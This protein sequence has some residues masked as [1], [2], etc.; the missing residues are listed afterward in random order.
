M[1]ARINIITLAVDDL[2]KA[3]RFYRDGLGLP[4]KGIAEGFSDHVLFE[5]ENDLSLVLFLRSET[6]KLANQPVSQRSA[7]ESI[8]SY[9][10]SSKEEVNDILRQQADHYQERLRINHGDILL[11]SRIPMDISGKYC[12]GLLSQGHRSQAGLFN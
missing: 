4:T 8:L 6:A 9:F 10:A 1:R 11:I 12:T 7:A 2:E 5:M 3:L